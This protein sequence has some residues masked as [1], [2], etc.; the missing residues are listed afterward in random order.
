MNLREQIETYIAYKRSLGLRFHTDA[1]I[2]RAF[3]RALGDIEVE[4]VTSDALRAF[5]AG[6]GPVT[7]FWRQKFSVIGSFY[8]YALA[9]GFVTNSPLPTWHPRIPPPLT[10][11]IYSVEELARL[12]AATETVRAANSP[13]QAASLRTLLQL[14]YG[15]GMRIGEALRLTLQDADL[16]EQLLTVRQTKFYKTRLVPIGPRLTRV[17][18]HYAA[19]RRRLALP[20]G[21]SSAFFATRTGRRLHYHNVNKLFRRVRHAADIRRESSARYQ[22][23]LHD[24]RHT[25]A[26]HR[27]TA[28]Y[29]SGADVQRLLPQLATYLGHADVASTQRYLHMTPELLNEASRR[30]EHYAQPE[31][32]HE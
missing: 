26:V 29:R 13:L 3:C 8:R 25:A 6:N 19:Q 5:L 7:A 30:F 16:P 15:T 28:W 12:W 4:E 18:A 24:I 32:D 21:E 31:A 23:R 2:L 17:L 20:A 11:Y 22:P 10:P 27:L 9:R 14:L 1:T